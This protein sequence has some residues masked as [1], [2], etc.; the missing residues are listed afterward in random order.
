MYFKCLNS[1]SNVKALV[2]T[3]NQEM[4]LE[5]DFSLIVKLPVI[6]GNR[7][8]KLYSTMCAGPADRGA[9]H[10]RLPGVGAGHLQREPGGQRPL[11]V[12]GH[13]ATCD[14]LTTEL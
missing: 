6:F 5:G 12:P 11:R 2:G 10:P 8:L 3:F 1:V 13:S 7:R 14:M 9:R 4:T